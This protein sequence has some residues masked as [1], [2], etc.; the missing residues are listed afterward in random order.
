MPRADVRIFYSGP[1]PPT[2]VNAFLQ[3]AAIQGQASAPSANQTSNPIEVSITG[4]A[5]VGAAGSVIPEFPIF[6]VYSDLVNNHVGTPIPLSNTR[7]WSDKPE[8]PTGG[9]VYTSISSLN[10]ALSTALP[11][12]VLKL[13]NGTYNNAT[14]NASAN[15]NSSNAITL[16]A[17]SVGGVNLTGNSKVNIS[18]NFFDYFGIDMRDTTN[19]S[20]DGL[21]NWTGTDGRMALCTMDNI[22]RTSE[23]ST[24]IRWLAINNADRCRVCYC[25]F[26]NKVTQGNDIGSFRSGLAFYCRIDHNEFLNHRGPPLSSGLKGSAMIHWGEEQPDV[27]AFCLF[28]NNYTFQWRVEADGTPVN[29]DNPSMWIFKSSANMHIQNVF[30]ECAGYMHVRHANRTSFYANWYIANGQEGSRGMHLGGRDNFSFCNYFSD[31]NQTAVFGNALTLKQGTV[32]ESN[33]YIEAERAE[34]SFN[35]F[36]N[37]RKTMAFSQTGSGTEDAQDC[38][39]YNNAIDKFPTGNCVSDSGQINFSYGGN[40]WEVPTG[41]GTTSGVTEAT[42]DLTLNGGFRV[43]TASGNCDATGVDRSGTWSVIATVDILGS[44]ISASS[45]NVGCFQPGFDLTDD[46]VQAIIDAA[47]V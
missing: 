22:A 23:P 36:F 24:R 3:G 43:P 15:G 47:G 2:G 17:Q 9:T 37:C 10:T 26:A 11:G 12:D 1:D 13:G 45:P 6:S 29:I 28:D 16:A 31:I 42:P 7:Y 25:K 33:F 44:D 34:V 8:I 20:S 39:L 5:I 19:N 18:G 4:A 32:G 46:P 40:V 21:V 14:I 30:K 27:D 35:T 41:L 38:K